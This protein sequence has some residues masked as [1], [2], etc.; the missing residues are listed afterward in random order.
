MVQ[1]ALLARERVK[2]L[3]TPAFFDTRG[4]LL[5]T[6]YMLTFC[7]VSLLCHCTWQQLNLFYTW[8]RPVSELCFIFSHKSLLPLD[9][10]YILQNKF[11]WRDSPTLE[12]IASLSPSL[13]L[14]NIFSSSAI[15]LFNSIPRTGL[16]LLISF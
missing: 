15:N 14:R 4:V 8:K 16:C 10:L 7:R 1:D 5:L 11:P 3:T 6:W 13:R 2:C 12:T 9:K